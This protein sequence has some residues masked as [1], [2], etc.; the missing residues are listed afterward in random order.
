[1]EQRRRSDRERTDDE[2]LSRYESWR[3]R[4]AE[5][6]PASYLAF[7]E[8]GAARG[9]WSTGRGHDATHHLPDHRI[10]SDD[11]HGADTTFLPEDEVE[12]Y[13][14]PMR[15]YRRVG[16]RFRAQ[17]GPHTGRGPRGYQRTDQRIREDVCE[18]LTEDGLVDASSIDVHVDNGEV[19]LEGNVTSRTQKRR[20]EDLTEIVLGV[21]DVHNRLRIQ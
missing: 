11:R 19:T 18:F 10:Y 7:R 2:D 12:T 17:R 6:P 14:G 5:V 3:H 4:P 9:Q 15:R 21:V 1:M 13:V 16:D 8:R 20:A